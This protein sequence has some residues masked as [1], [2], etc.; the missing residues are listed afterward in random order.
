[1]LSSAGI[2][3]LAIELVLRVFFAAQ[4]A[5][6]YAYDEDLL[7]RHVTSAERFFRQLPE[8]G[9]GQNRITINSDGYRGPE[10]DKSGTARRIAVYGDSLIFSSAS[11]YEQTFPAQLQAKL[12]AEGETALDVVNAGVS[13]YGLDQIYLRMKRELADLAPA[14]VVLAVYSGNDFGDSVTNNLFRL[15][16]RGKLQRNTES[17][18][19]PLREGIRQAT[20]KSYLLKLWESRIRVLANRQAKPVPPPDPYGRTENWLRSRQNEFQRYIVGREN[21]I[22]TSVL[23][24]YYDADVAMLPHS[25]SARYKIQVLKALMEKIRSLCDRHG[26]PLAILIIPHPIDAVAGYEVA[27]VDTSKYPDYTRSGLSTVVHDIAVDL[28]VPA[29]N[30]IELFGNEDTRQFYLRGGDPHWNSLGQA[31]AAEEMM[32]LINTHKLLH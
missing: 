26:I 10:L 31:F 5:P 12:L 32:E 29:V 18:P 3:L 14:L 11:R 19:A 25:D 15:D 16:E 9:G 27:Q 22:T 13:A 23:A 1:M 20:R 28:N 6:I 24:D 21:R 2:T 8:N 7:F 30:L 17:D 4:Y